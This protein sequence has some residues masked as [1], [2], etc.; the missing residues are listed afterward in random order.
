MAGTGEGYEFIEVDERLIHA[1]HIDAQIDADLIIFLSR[2]YS[3][4][5]VPVLTVHVTGNFGTA[6]VGGTARTLAPAA[7]E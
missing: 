1:E 5:P 3:V 6:E 4:N 2:H 7:P